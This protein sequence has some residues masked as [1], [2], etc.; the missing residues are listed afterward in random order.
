MAIAVGE[1]GESQ[2]W[3]DGSYVAFHTANFTMGVSDANWLASR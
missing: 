2:A 1:G 3:W